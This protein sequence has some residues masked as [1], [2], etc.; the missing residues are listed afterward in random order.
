[1]FRADFTI[2]DTA[3]VSLIEYTRLS[4]SPF[5]LGKSHTSHLKESIFLENQS[6]ID[7]SSHAQREKSFGCFY[8]TVVNKFHC[9]KCLFY[10]ENNNVI[11]K[12]KNFKSTLLTTSDS[13]LN[14]LPRNHSLI[15]EALK[16]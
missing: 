15:K 3:E 10:D 5:H 16:R 13:E 11:P 8:M 9:N 7:R 2:A 4:L 14:P 1:M 12:L 6:S